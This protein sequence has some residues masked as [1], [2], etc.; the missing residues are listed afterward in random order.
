MANPNPIINQA[1]EQMIRESI[2]DTKRLMDT[3][4]FESKRKEGP[5]YDGLRDAAA[6]LEDY[7]PTVRVK[8]GRMEY[9]SPGVYE[10]VEGGGG[11]IGEDT[12]QL[13]L[14]AGPI[15]QITGY[16]DDC[17]SWIDAKVIR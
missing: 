1:F 17:D 9:Q 4:P 16:G 5:R 3:I 13:E 7:A 15:I 11:A 8:L 2:A 6:T 14:A 10:F 12:I